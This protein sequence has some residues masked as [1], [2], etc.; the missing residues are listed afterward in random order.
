MLVA[1]LEFDAKFPAMPQAW[2]HMSMLKEHV[3]TLH[4]HPYMLLHK[5]ATKYESA[6]HRCREMMLTDLHYAVTL[7]NPYS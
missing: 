7:L 5:T 4:E 2:M 3:Y 1:Y 6:I